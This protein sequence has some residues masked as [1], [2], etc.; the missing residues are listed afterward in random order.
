[1]AGTGRTST[2]GTPPS[3][4]SGLP[5]EQR[6]IDVAAAVELGRDQFG[7]DQFGRDPREGDAVAAVAEHCVHPRPPRQAADHRQPG[8]G[9]AEAPGPG[10]F[11]RGDLGLNT[12]ILN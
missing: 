5:R 3:R 2:S 7:R 12:D 4:S 11:R 10:E 6:R 8:P 9:G 1:M